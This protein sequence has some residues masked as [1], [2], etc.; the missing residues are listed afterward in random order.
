[1]STDGVANDPIGVERVEPFKD[2][3]VVTADPERVKIAKG[4][5]AF[6]AIRTFGC[7]ETTYGSRTA[8]SCS[9]NSLVRVSVVMQWD[10][11]QGVGTAVLVIPN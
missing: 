2:R 8:H 10:G 11:F 1:M 9:K 4:F 3:N 6:W 5:L 7:P